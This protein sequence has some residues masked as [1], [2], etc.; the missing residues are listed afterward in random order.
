MGS[1]LISEDACPRSLFFNHLAA[2]A[3][4]RVFAA[5]RTPTVGFALVVSAC[6]LTSGPVPALRASGGGAAG[7]LTLTVSGDRFAVDGQPRFLLGVS[8]FDAL[9]PTPPSDRDLDQL[10]QW[11]VDLVRVWAHWHDPI[12]DASGSV[13]A[14]GRERLL[15]L[16]SRLEARGLSLDLVLLRPGQLPGQRFALFSS[17]A[18]R[19]RAVER[20]TTLLKQY[21]SVMF[22]LCNEYDHDDGPITAAE[23]R[24]LRDAVKAIDGE[25]IVAM[26]FTSAG[27]FDAEQRLGADGRQ[28]LLAQVGTSADSIGVDVVAP[29][30]PRTRDWAEATGTRVATLIAALKA[31]GVEAPILLDEERRAEAGGLALAAR[32]YLTA[33]AGAEQ[34]GAAGWILHTSAGFDLGERSFTSALNDQERQALATLAGRRPSRRPPS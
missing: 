12:Y 10:A 2:V 27:L 31:M 15:R 5:V 1:G 23:G 22:D 7:A 30:L 4:P 34:S 13:T 3:R 16:V 24:R 25:R 18:A 17:S 32:E 19:L 9:G 6:V 26:S 8:L 33:E 20:I 21:R 11:R 29:H 14:A 28:Q